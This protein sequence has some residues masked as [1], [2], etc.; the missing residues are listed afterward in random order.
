[1]DEKIAVARCQHGVTG[2]HAGC[3]HLIAIYKQQ[4]TEIARLTA[5]LTARQG[6]RLTFTN[7]RRV[8]SRKETNG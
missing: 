6:D 1:M 5:E 4:K 7:L 8:F 3:V 2:Y